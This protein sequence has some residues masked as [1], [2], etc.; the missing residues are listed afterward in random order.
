[1]ATQIVLDATTPEKLRDEIVR[2]LL[3]N[4]KQLRNSQLSKDNPRVSLA[5]LTDIAHEI[6]GARLHVNVLERR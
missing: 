4:V 1:M 3:H 5:V 6:A 2:Y